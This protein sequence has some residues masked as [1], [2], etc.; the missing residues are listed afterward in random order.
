[1][2]KVKDII[3]P[4]ALQS[5][6]FYLAFSNPPSIEPLIKLRSLGAELGYVGVLLLN[7]QYREK[8][9][10]VPSKTEDSTYGLRKNEMNLIESKAQ[11]SIS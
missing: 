11:H 9:Q 5:T 8:K 6:S 3:R 1:M 2:Q 4:P 10:M 7:T